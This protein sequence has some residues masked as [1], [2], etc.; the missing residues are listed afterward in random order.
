MEAIEKEH[1]DGRKDV[2]IVVGTLDVSDTDDA[3]LRAKEVIEKEIIPKLADTD[4]RV[5]VVYREPVDGKFLFASK[6]VKVPQVRAYAEACV[7]AFVEHHVQN[8][9]RKHFMVVEHYPNTDE[10]KITQ[11]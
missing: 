4:V 10:V 6:K 2:K 3:T 9:D 8:A 11:L 1:E 7:N 5:T